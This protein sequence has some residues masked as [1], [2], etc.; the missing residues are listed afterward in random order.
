MAQG[1][2]KTEIKDIQA[3]H[4]FINVILSY[5]EWRVSVVFEDEPSVVYFYGF[6][7]DGE[8]SQSGVSGGSADMEKEDLKHIE[9]LK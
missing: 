1:Y 2:T 7:N 8:I 3:R 5:P 9:P 6:N 4:S